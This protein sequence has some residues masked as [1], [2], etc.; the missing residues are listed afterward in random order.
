MM[1]K[2]FLRFGFF[3]LLL[4]LYTWLIEPTWIKEQKIVVESTTHGAKNIEL[5]VLHLSDIHYSSTVSTKYITKVF[6][7][8]LANKPD[9]I[10]LTG[11][12]ITDHIINKQEYIGAL[13]ILSNSAPTFA[14][15]GNHDGGIWSSK[16]NGYSTNDSVSSLLKKANIQILQNE[17]VSLS[18]KNRSLLIGGVGDLWSGY[19]HPEL[20]KTQFDTSKADAKILLSHNP[21]T[22]NMVANINWELLLCGHT[23]GGQ[24]YLPIIG[25]PFAP[26]NDQSTVKGLYPFENK[27]YVNVSG[28]IGNVHGLRFNCRPEYTVIH[29]WL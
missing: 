1:T 6:S 7:K 10:L 28:G 9:L 16:H 12:Y 5:K 2:Y 23:H 19:F 24:F 11:D 13:K 4:V 21:D 29:I 15:L 18:I 25:A 20:I 17:T 14:I 27:R 3:I 26:V 8:A 22:K